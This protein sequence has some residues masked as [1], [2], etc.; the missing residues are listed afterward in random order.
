LERERPVGKDKDSLV[1]FV[2]CQFS[3]QHP[4]P[5]AAKTSN[6]LPNSLTRQWLHEVSARRRHEERVR[7]E[8]ERRRCERGRREN[9][10]SD[11]VACRQE[12]DRFSTFMV[13]CNCLLVIS[14][15]FVC[16][17]CSLSLCVCVCVCVCVCMCVCVCCVYVCY[18]LPATTAAPRA[19]EISTVVGIHFCS[20]DILQVRIDVITHNTKCVCVG[21]AFCLVSC[22]SLFLRPEPN[23]LSR[24]F[25]QDVC[26]GKCN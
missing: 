15:G 26:G 9:E 21:G 2:S 1:T 24:Q 18:P 8:G 11:R 23:Q 22:V 6:Q 17:N 19:R 25:L 14:L 4:T 20:S 3:V 5:L 13:A 16:N 10:A 7:E 12:G